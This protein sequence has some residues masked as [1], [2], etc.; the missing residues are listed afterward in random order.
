[1]AY[2]DDDNY[3]KQ[4]LLP[5]SG[6]FM[7]DSEKAALIN[8]K[9]HRRRR[10]RVNHGNATN[11]FKEEEPN[12]NARGLPHLPQSNPNCAT[13]PNIRHVFAFLAV[14]LGLGVL[15]FCLLKDQIKG[16]KTNGVV[17]ALYFCIVTMTTVG[18]GD[19]VPDSTA[20][21]LI[22]CVF[23]FA[24]M[25]LV[26]HILS[27]SADRLVER[28]E[29]L[30]VKAMHL[31]EKV[32]EAEMLKEMEINRSKY[33]L[34]TALAFLV[35][36]MVVGQ[37]FLCLV[38]EMELVDAFYCVCST[39]TTLGYGDESFSTAVGRGFAVIWILSSTICLAQFFLYLAEMYAESRQRSLVKWVLTRKTT[40]ADLEAADIDDDDVVSAA[41]FVVYKLKEMG[42]ISEEDLKLLMDQ[43]RNLDVDHS[44]TL[45]A[46][47]LMFSQP[48]QAPPLSLR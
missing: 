27:R 7:E 26:G 39:I 43:F 40:A 34:W 3:A 33:K 25:V 23:V 17:D 32:G 29:I 41:E 19:L 47:D 18:Y 37:L 21:K 31:H 28:Q 9:T 42:K 44:G 13:S 8:K 22:A 4:P 46:A 5:S 6:T 30:L 35:T 36:L 38:E 10:R 15:C 12:G 1:M 16:K 20:A 24:G 14:Y 2:G 45:T 11:I 48:P